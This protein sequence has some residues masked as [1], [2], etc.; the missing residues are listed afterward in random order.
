MLMFFLT[1]FLSFTHYVEGNNNQSA[2]S[3]QEKFNNAAQQKD[4]SKRKVDPKIIAQLQQKLTVAELSNELEAKKIEQLADEQYENGLAG[5]VISIIII[6]AKPELIQQLDQKIAVIANRFFT[7]TAMI[8][9]GISF[10]NFCG[11]SNSK[12]K[13][14]KECNE[15]RVLMTE[16]KDLLN[17][18]L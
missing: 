9:L 14:L 10:L 15:K 6:L 16:I 17:K 8:P 12:L 7:I 3:Q 11:P 5:S 1:F 13:K 2:H 4:S 18:L